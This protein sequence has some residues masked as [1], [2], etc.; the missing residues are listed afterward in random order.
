MY[1]QNTVIYKKDYYL[2]IAVYFNLF[3][4]KCICVSVFM[5]EKTLSLV[6][7][8]KCWDWSL[9]SLSEMKL[10]SVFITPQVCSSF[11]SMIYSLIKLRVILLLIS[12]FFSDKWDV[13]ISV[14][15]E[16]WAPCINV[17]AFITKTRQKCE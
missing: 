2:F 13:A 15:K 12:S 16:T 4:I 1:L 8:I 7:T 5:K 3:C 10:C 17:F 11:Y 14:M 9:W 6:V